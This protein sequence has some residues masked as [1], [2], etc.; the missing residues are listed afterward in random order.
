VTEGEPYATRRS[1]RC[2]RS[3]ASGE[4]KG[5]QNVSLP[6]AKVGDE[7]VEKALTSLRE[8][9]ARFVGIDPRPSQG[10][11]R[12]PSTS[13]AA[14]TSGKGKDFKH[15]GGDGRG[16]GGQQPAGVQ[17]GAAGDERRRVEV[18][19][20]RLSAGLRRREPRG[21]TIAYTLTVRQIKVREIP[22]AD[23]EL[24]KDVGKTGTLAE[25]RE[26]IRK[27]LTE[28]LRANH[29]RQARESLLRHLIESNTVQVPEVMVEDQLNSQ[30]EDIVRQMI[31]RGVDPNKAGVDWK[32]MRE[33]SGPSP[34]KRVLGMLLLDEIAGGSRSRSRRGAPRARSRREIRAAASHSAKVKK[35]L[36]EPETRTSP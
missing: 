11:L 35:R 14:D 19:R 25:L 27:D 20:S 36:D 30:L 16:R 12:G 13:R 24:P 15:D 28:S 2:V 8:R 10:G 29:E 4:Y 18:L 26:Q 17:H 22:P 23:D 32:A 7:E 1:S 6:E 3:C 9:L 31:V 21:R 5:T 33:Q 34:K